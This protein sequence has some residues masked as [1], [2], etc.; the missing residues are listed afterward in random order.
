MPHSNL[1]HLKWNS[2]LSLSPLTPPPFVVS[3]TDLKMKMTWMPIY[4]YS[5]PPLVLKSAEP[6][7]QQDAIHLHSSYQSRAPDKVSPCTRL[8]K[9]LL[10]PLQDPIS[11]INHVRTHT[12]K[13]YMQIAYSVSCI[14]LYNMTKFVF[15][16][17]AYMNRFNWRQGN[18]NRGIAGL[19]IPIC[20]KSVS[21]YSFSSVSKVRINLSLF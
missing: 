5:S 17:A 16:S 11:F 8:S 21:V 10:R 9:P 14:E 18:F 7:K 1:I 15:G 19:M 6:G 12:N 13:E 3:C 20:K 2:A 4:H